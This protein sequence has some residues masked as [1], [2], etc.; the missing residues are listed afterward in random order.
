M[1]KSKNVYFINFNANWKQ[2]SWSFRAIT[3]VLTLGCMLESAEELRNLVLLAAA[4]ASSQGMG[5]WEAFQVVL[6]GS[7]ERQ[8]DGC[9]MVFVLHDTQKRPKGLV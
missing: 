1:D 2:V 5:F 7:S 6:M 4:P 9:A 3:S 8:G